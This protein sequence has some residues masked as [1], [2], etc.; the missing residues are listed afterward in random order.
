MKNLFIVAGL[1]AMV[2]FSGCTEDPVGQ[3]PALA[4]GQSYLNHDGDNFTAPAFPGGN[5]E[6]AVRFPA[7][8]LQALVGDQLTQIAYFIR[9]TPQTCAVRVYTRTSSGEPDSVIYSGITTS[10]VSGNTW[11]VHTLN[12]P[13]SIDGQDLWISVRFT[14]LDRQQTIGC[15]PGPRVTNGDFILTDGQSWTTFED[16][17]GGE[18]INWNIRGIVE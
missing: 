4:E 10:Q 6:A 2:F 13:V 9:S 15:D 3:A 18:S 7:A 11:N 12:D 17:T 5:H 8:E 16:L 1:S 14:H